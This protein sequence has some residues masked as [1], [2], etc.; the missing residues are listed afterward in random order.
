MKRQDTSLVK[1]GARLRDI[2]KR[3]RAPSDG[4]GSDSN[5]SGS[6]RGGGGDMLQRS[7]TEQFAFGRSLSKGSSFKNSASNMPPRV[8]VE[9]R[10]LE[11]IDSDSE[12]DMDELL[13]S[14]TK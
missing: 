9:Q 10:E 5:Y 8:I 14:P 4:S 13:L 11:R 1:F 6:A 2:R 12:K 3:S 7:I